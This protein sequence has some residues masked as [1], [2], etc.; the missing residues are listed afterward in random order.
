M[1]PLAAVP[2]KC[3]I[4]IGATRSKN[5]NEILVSLVWNQEVCEN[6]ISWI[7]CLKY[8]VSNFK[9]FFKDRAKLPFSKPIEH[10]FAGYFLCLY[11][12]T[13]PRLFQT[14]PPGPPFQP[15]LHG[16]L[17]F[18]YVAYR[19][20]TWVKGLATD[21]RKTPATPQKTPKRRYNSSRGNN[22]PQLTLCK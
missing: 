4:A 21:T 22:N 12:T 5:Y 6:D 2:E 17:S 3:F 14:P 8:Y 18:Y 9:W 16:C 13:D 11:T 19:N 20:L 1:C 10:Y 15:P 7:S